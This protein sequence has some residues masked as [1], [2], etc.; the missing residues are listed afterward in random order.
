MQIVQIDFKKQDPPVFCLQ[1]M[2]LT[3]KDTQKL[4]VKG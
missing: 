1:E 4:K 2:I 3:G